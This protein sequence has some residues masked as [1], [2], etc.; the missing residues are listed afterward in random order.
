M[1]LILY[2]NANSDL[3]E[4]DDTFTI[5]VKKVA[6]FSTTDLDPDGFQFTGKGVYSAKVDNENNKVYVE[7]ARK[8]DA[9]DCDEDGEWT[10]G[11]QN[12]AGAQMVVSTLQN[13]TINDSNKTSLMVDVDAD[14]SFTVTSEDKSKTRSSR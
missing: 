11:E 12:R 8:T 13:A 9:D 2:R 7:L 10:E 3:E 6:K 4:V 1:T 14:D 5:T